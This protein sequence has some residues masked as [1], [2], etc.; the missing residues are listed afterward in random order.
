MGQASRP[1]PT[2]SEAGTRSE[3]AEERRV[4]HRPLPQAY[5]RERGEGEICIEV[6]EVEKADICEYYV[7]PMRTS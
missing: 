1:D 4:R 7:R 2:G 5:K 6:G 3:P